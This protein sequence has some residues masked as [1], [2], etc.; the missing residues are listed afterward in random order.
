MIGM[1]AIRWIDVNGRPILH[2]N[3]SECPDMKHDYKTRRW[4]A[5]LRKWVWNTLAQWRQKRLA[6]RAFTQIS[7]RKSAH[8]LEDIGLDRMDI[9]RDQTHGSGRH[10]WML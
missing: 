10:F 6:R 3:M 2:E 9:Y 5:R 4:P 1:F 7:R 8:L